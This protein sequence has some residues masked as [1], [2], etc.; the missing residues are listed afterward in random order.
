MGG[1]GTP[2]GGDSGSDSLAA[3]AQ[4]FYLGGSQE[5]YDPEQSIWEYTSE[6]TPRRSHLHGSRVAWS[7]FV[8]STLARFI[9]LN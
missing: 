4:R 1:Q 2:G 5:T 9:P 3:G 6:R 7:P 8:I